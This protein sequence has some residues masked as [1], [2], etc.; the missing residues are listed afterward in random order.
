M[1]ATFYIQTS[2]PK[3]SGGLLSAPFRVPA[4]SL[5][6]LVELLADDGIVIVEQ[7]HLAAADSLGRQEIVGSRKIGLGLSAILAIQPYRF[8]LR[9]PVSGRAA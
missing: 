4:A 2:I 7:L 1:S 9:E 5:E 3:P 6:A 8:T